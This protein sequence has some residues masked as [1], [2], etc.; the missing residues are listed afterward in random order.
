MEIKHFSNLGDCSQKKE[1]CSEAFFFDSE[2]V[3]FS[4][5]VKRSQPFTRI[6][7][8]VSNFFQSF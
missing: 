8:K 2:K 4:N 1:Q 3:L 5:A 7:A 6:T